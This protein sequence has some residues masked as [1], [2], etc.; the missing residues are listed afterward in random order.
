MKNPKEAFQKKK[1]MPQSQKPASKPTG[2]PGTGK[3]S[4]HG[5]SRPKTPPQTPKR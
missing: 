4:E 3:P 2:Q 1:E 5:P